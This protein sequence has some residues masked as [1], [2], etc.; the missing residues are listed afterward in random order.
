MNPDYPDTFVFTNDFAA[1]R[2]GHER[3]PRGRRACSAPRAPAAP[4]ASCASRRATTSRSRAWTSA[5]IRA[6]RSTSGRTRRP[7]SGG[8]YRWVQVFENRGAAMGASN[9][10]PHG[11]I[12]AGDALPVEASLE[13]ARQAEHLAATGSRLLLDYALAGARAGRA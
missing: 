5:A 13:A 10:H 4:A 1:L 12:W 11:Q 8:R 2:P 3:R 6:R 7:S 9:P